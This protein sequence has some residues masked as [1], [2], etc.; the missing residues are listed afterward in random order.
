MPVEHFALHLK[1]RH[2][3]LALDAGYIGHLDDHHDRE[4]AHAHIHTSD[5]LRL[6]A[7]PA[8][9]AEAIG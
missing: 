8:P 6:A 1:L 3:H 5:A 9:G 2:P 4:R 7:V